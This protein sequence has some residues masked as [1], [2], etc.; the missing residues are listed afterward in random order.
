MKKYIFIVVTIFAMSVV[1][2]CSDEPEIENNVVEAYKAGDVTKNFQIE[3]VKIFTKDNPNAKWERVDEDYMIDLVYDESILFNNG[4][5]C[6][7]LNLH[8]MSDDLSGELL[9]VWSA[10]KKVTKCDNL[11]YTTVAFQLD[12]ATNR[13]KI[14]NWFFNVEVMTETELRINDNVYENGTR[15]CVYTYKLASMSQS[16]LDKIVYF[17]SRKDAYLYIVKVA[18]EY[19]GDTIDLNKIYSPNIIFD[20]PIID[21]NELEERIELEM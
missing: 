3:S 20:E 14:N 4:R 5:V 17:D 8:P 18:S 13:M 12:Q 21:L 16:E 9:M 7:A 6:T 15:K 19:F 10:Y 1:C 11:L 2:S